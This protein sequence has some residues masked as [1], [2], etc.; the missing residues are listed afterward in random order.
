MD[1]PSKPTPEP[2]PSAVLIRLA[3]IG[4]V[5]AAVSGFIFGAAKIGATGMIYF[6]TGSYAGDG[7][8]IGLIAAAIAFFV[9]ARNAERLVEMVD[10]RE[11]PALYAM[12]G[13]GGG[14]GLVAG[15][16]LTLLINI[17]AA[18]IQH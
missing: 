5:A 12:I 8:V 9:C 3:S 6:M 15:L 11:S 2:V 10:R 7:A 18:R 1:V 14:I 4:A 13:I 16:L 17:V